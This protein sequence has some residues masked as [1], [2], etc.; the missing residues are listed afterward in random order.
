MSR[1]DKERQKLRDDVSSGKTE[2]A[3]EISTLENAS[4]NGINY[5]GSEGNSTEQ[6]SELM[7]KIDAKLSEATYYGSRSVEMCASAKSFSFAISVFVCS[8]I[9]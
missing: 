6:V 8:S 7:A 5:S 9:E 1:L 4:I 3:K 2:L